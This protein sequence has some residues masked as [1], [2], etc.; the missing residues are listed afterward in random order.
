MKKIFLFL[1]SLFIISCSSIDNN[2]SIELKNSIDVIDEVGEYQRKDDTSIVNNSDI[3]HEEVENKVTVLEIDIDGKKD[4]NEILKILE[5]ENLSSQHYTKVIKSFADW[6]RDRRYDSRDLEE[7]SKINLL[8]DKSNNKSKILYTGIINRSFSNVSYSN[9]NMEEL[10]ENYYYNETRGGEL[11][12]EIFE[13]ISPRTYAQKYLDNNK[14]L[15]NAL[16]NIGSLSTQYYSNKLLNSYQVMSPEM[17]MLSRSE[18]LEVKSIVKENDKYVRGLKNII[19]TDENG[20]RYYDRSYIKILMKPLLLRSFTVSTEDYLIDSNNKISYGTSFAAPRISRLAY[21]IKEKYPFLS[22]QQVKQVI[23]GATN[24]P[25]DGYLSDESGWG[26]VD[27]EKALK[28]PSDFN[29]GLIEEQKY[30]R[31]NYDKIYDENGNRY[32]YVD[33]PYGKKYEFSNNII[34]GL[35]GDGN[36]KEAKIVEVYGKVNETQKT[37]IFEYRIPRVLD[38]ERL[39]YANIAQAG[40]RKDGLGELVLSGKQEY[41]A[42]TQVLNGKLT[43]SNDSLSN[44]YISKNAKFNISSNKTLNLENIYTDGIV[45]FDSNVKMKE[46]RGSKNSTILFKNENKTIILDSFKT[47]GKYKLETNNSNLDLVIRVKNGDN[48][49]ND[50]SLSNVYLKVNRIDNDKYVDIKFSYNLNENRK[51]KDLSLEEL[52][53]IPSYNINERKFFEKYIGLPYKSKP[54]PLPN[55]DRLAVELANMEEKDR[56]LTFGDNYSTFIGSLLQ[57]ELDDKDIFHNIYFSDMNK[58]NKLSLENF[59]KSE[60]LSSHLYSNFNKYRAGAILSY[61]YGIN[62]FKLDVFGKYSNSENIFNHEKYKYS[63]ISNG[64]NLGLNLATR[65]DIL[66]FDFSTSYMFNNAKSYMEKDYLGK[67]NTNILD[68]EMILSKKFYA[69]SIKSIFRPYI[70]SSLSLIFSNGRDFNGIRKMEDSFNRNFNIG[71]GLQTITNIKD[72]LDVENR[73][74]LSY[75]TLDKIGLNNEFLDLKYITEGKGLDKFNFKYIGSVK[76][77]ILDDLKIGGRFS[78]NQRLKLGLNLGIEYNF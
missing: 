47:A 3:I 76:Y 72:K 25:E 54:Y 71:L 16:G 6:N 44:Y 19:L 1:L 21:E 48:D 33:I 60:I 46:L 51:L 58:S 41:R 40:L 24:R 62:N 78:I 45:E 20:N 38:S 52:R 61:S 7:F 11:L 57:D 27:F 69:N 31:G 35:K 28:G 53:N 70:S 29:A 22:Y 37:D 66:D 14:L 32:F 34:S 75:N 67:I 68:F 64:Y 39:F 49:F 26:Y 17:Q 12:K 9:T 63:L 23:L 36:T 42:N 77:S 59:V 73:I 65:N 18:S 10:S 30:F 13:Y 55:Y 2:I 4:K 56:Y 43:L 74:Y 8:L 5:D 15:I 50:E